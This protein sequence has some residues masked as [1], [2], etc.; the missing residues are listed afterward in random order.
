MPTRVEQLPY[1]TMSDV[2][3]KIQEQITDNSYISTVTKRSL[4]SINSKR[5]R[6]N[7]NNEDHAKSQS[8]HE[9]QQGAKPNAQCL[10]PK[11]ML[12]SEMP[13]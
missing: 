5:V 11:R 7:G 1:R 6:V 10:C 12:A 3:K 8:L 9:S 2:K 4:D 13:I